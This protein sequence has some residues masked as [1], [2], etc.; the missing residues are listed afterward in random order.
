MDKVGTKLHLIFQYFFWQHWWILSLRWDKKF[1]GKQNKVKL[2]CIRWKSMPSW[3]RIWRASNAQIS[4]KS[5]FT[6]ILYFAIPS[7]FWSHRSDKIPQL[8]K[9]IL[10]IV[11]RFT[12]KKIFK[13]SVRSLVSFM[14]CIYALRYWRVKRYGL[15]LHNFANEVWSVKILIFQNEHRKKTLL[16]PVCVFKFY[17]QRKNN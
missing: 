14:M 6:T 16:L 9:K 5:S 8:S 7:N 17:W 1:D 2:M 15:Y 4:L 12:S 10:N 3:M 13:H 11:G